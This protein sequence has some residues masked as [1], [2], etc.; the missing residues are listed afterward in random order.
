MPSYAYFTS[1]HTLFTRISDWLV[2]EIVTGFINHCHRM[3]FVGCTVE[4]TRNHFRAVLSVP[5]HIFSAQYMLFQ[6]LWISF[7]HNYLSDYPYS[8]ILASPI[9]TSKGYFM[10]TS[11]RRVPAAYISCVYR[12]SIMGGCLKTKISVTPGTTFHGSTSA[13]FQYS[14]LQPKSPIRCELESSVLFKTSP[15]RDIR[16][17][18][19]K[20]QLA[21]SR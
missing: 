19:G 21:M 10:R 6:L 8:S 18:L 3:P 13:H 2:F 12:S 14:Q 17:Y 16:T 5:K 9:R 15:A 1:A 4:D 11:S 20:R 7:H